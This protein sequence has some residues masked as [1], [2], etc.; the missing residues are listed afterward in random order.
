M[1][2]RTFFGY[3]HRFLHKTLDGWSLDYFN[4]GFSIPKF[5]GGITVNEEFI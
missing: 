4:Y 1:R 2:S 5:I 3:S